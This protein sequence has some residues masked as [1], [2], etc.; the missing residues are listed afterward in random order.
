MDV[1]RIIVAFPTWIQN[2]PLRLDSC[3]TEKPGRGIGYFAGM[4]YVSEERFSVDKD[5][6]SLIDARSESKE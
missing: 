3:G 4:T 1:F 6:G 5:A 2:L